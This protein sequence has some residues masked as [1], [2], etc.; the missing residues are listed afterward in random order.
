VLTGRTKVLTAKTA[1]LTVRDVG[2]CYG[3]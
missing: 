2:R 3:R 1:L